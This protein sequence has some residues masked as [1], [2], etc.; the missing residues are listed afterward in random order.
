M[1]Q[2]TL[3]AEP[4]VRGADP[5]APAWAAYL[6]T[7]RDECLTLVCEA[8]DLTRGSL[9]AGESEGEVAA[10]LFAKD[11]DISL[12]AA[13]MNLLVLSEGRFTA[14]CARPGFSHPRAALI[15]RMTDEKAEGALIDDLAEIDAK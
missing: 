5:D 2:R 8:F 15:D 3:I 4:A 7:K 9:L 13:L 14:N 10:V 6:N 11:E 12:R 1:P